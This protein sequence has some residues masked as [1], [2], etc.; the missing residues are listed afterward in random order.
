MRDQ[1]APA[2]NPIISPSFWVFFG[3]PLDQSST[4]QFTIRF[5]GNLTIDDTISVIDTSRFSIES[6]TC[7]SGSFV[8]GNTCHFTVRYAPSSGLGDE[9]GDTHTT[10]IV[11]PV[12][13]DRDE[14]YVGIEGNVG[15]LFFTPFLIGD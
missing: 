6:D 4:W 12:S 1:G 15:A 7:S 13:N 10:N 11:I 5:H 2:G 3:V 9:N 8:D 14:L